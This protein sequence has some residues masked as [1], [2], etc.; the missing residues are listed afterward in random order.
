VADLVLVRPLV[1]S[2]RIR[3]WVRVF[4]VLLA[5]CGIACLPYGAPAHP[6]R[7]TSLFYG[8]VELGSFM[9]VGFALIIASLLVFALSFIGR[10]S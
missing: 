8:F 2:M 3:D 1:P 7:M 5:A 9:R 4:A 6:E 10:A